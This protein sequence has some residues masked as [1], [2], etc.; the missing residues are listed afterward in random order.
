M[1][2]KPNISAF[3]P[4]YNEEANVAKLTSILLNVLRDVAFDY[5]VIIVNDGSSDRTGEIARE[6]CQKDAHVRVVEHKSNQGY[7][8]AV[9]SGLEAT[10]LD[11]V[12]FTDGDGQFDVKEIAK[13]LP[14]LNDYKVIIG[15][16][17]K[18]QDNFI[19][20]LNTRGWMGLTKF[21]FPQL[22]DIRDYSCAF[23]FFKKEILNNITFKTTG[24]MI[25]MELLLN[26]INRGYQIK[27]IGVQHYPRQAGKQTGANIKVISRAFKE[28]FRFYLKG[29]S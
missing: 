23:K 14:Y 15:Y 16:R 28:L 1:Q 9:R 20:G 22:R 26:I 18:R 27:Q 4:A 24:A 5:E 6:L 11:W 25:S 12:F 3:F 8:A 17:I 7:G 10:R 2:L 19:R 29:R 13:F 21:L